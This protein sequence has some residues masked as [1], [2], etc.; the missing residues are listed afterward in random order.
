MTTKNFRDDGL[1]GRIYQYIQRHPGKWV[2][3]GEIEELAMK[4]GYKASNSKRRLEELAEADMLA[5]DYFRAGERSKRKTAHY[6]Y[7]PELIPS[8]TQ[9]KIAFEYRQIG[10]LPEG[11]YNYFEGN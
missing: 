11:V 1:K 5:V 10:G 8:L 3:G 2:N 7:N 9:E 6:C 4:A